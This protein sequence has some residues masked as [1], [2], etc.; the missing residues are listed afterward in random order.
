MNQ[1]TL[2]SSLKVSKII[3]GLWQIADMEKDGS[4][5]DLAQTSAHMEPYVE[6]GLTTFDMADHYG[7]SELIA[8]HFQANS[9]RKVQLLTKWVPKPGKLTKAEVRAGIQERLDRLQV[10]TIDLLQYH[11][12]NYADA[13]YLDQLLYLTELKE[14]GLI[15]NLG[16]TNF[17]AAH[18]RMVVSAGIPVVSNQICYSLLDQRA[19]GDMTKTCKELSI[20]ILAFG[21][22]G[23]G[24]LSER[25]LG[26]PEPAMDQ[27]SNWSLMKYKRFI[28][29]AGG[30][31]R[32]QQLLQLLDT[33]SEK[34]A[35]TISQLATRYM[36]D[37][38]AVAGIIIGARLGESEHLAQN[39]Q[40]LN[41]ELSPTDTATIYEFISGS[42][43]IP[44]ECGDEYR[45]PPYLT[46]SGDLSHHI[47]QLPA[48]FQTE[49]VGDT[50]KAFSGT[51]WEKEFGYCRASRTG[52]RILVSGTTSSHGDLLVGADD[53]ATQTH[54]VI[55]KIE[56]AILSLGGKLEDVV[57]TRIYVTREAD[58]RAIA[59]VH[60]QR[61]RDIQ[62]ANTLVQSG[63]IGPEFRVEIEAE[64]VVS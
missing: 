59:E 34:N 37:Q 26:R 7:S 64:A 32:F 28:D 2:S 61:F 21:T 31:S 36:L 17:D 62:P 12:W 57:R 56:G 60:G 58:W 42:P 63:L 25:W 8:G 33:I 10:P 51:T 4:E 46:A 40:V 22:V 48:P 18:L 19:A 52:N 49:I 38:E 41:I 15:K 35:C 24:F 3:T 44:G 9:D 14:E 47:D 39:L 53:P 30:W 55:D 43:K 16:V 1:T 50:T 45:K 11:A 54:F 5:L 29:Q 27:L 13:S 6:A 20:G 23:G